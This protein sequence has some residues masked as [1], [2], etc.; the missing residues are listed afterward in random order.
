MGKRTKAMSRGPCHTHRRYS[1]SVDLQRNFVRLYFLLTR[2]MLQI[3]SSFVVDEKPLSSVTLPSQV[4]VLAVASLQSYYAAAASAPTNDIHIF[5]K[6]DLKRSIAIL[7]GH[8]G[9]ITALHSVHVI[10]SARSVLLSCGKD[11]IIRAWDDRTG[12]AA[13]ESQ[14]N[15]LCSEICFDGA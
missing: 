7:K 9:A 8:Q 6:S 11:R 14:F 3:S 5:D 13:I 10:G 15:L 4:Y 12:A 2:N 1:G